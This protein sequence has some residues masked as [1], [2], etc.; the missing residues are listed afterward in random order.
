MHMGGLSVCG[1]ITGQ[2]HIA[3]EQRRNP[4]GS[5]AH[6]TG[7]CSS[8]SRE[9]VSG[10]RGGFPVTHGTPVGVDLHVQPGA[11]FPTVCGPVRPR[12][13]PSLCPCTDM[14]LAPSVSPAYEVARGPTSAP[15]PSPYG[16]R[17]AE[18]WP[19]MCGRQQSPTRTASQGTARRP[20]AGDSPSAFCVYFCAF[21]HLLKFPF[22]GDAR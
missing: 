1:G 9:A 16:G 12:P 4:R 7:R 2:D 5:S 20:P 19:A 15:V 13:H 21:V 11:A 18:G 6:G 14:K 10:P 3:V 17:Q 22:L 8:A